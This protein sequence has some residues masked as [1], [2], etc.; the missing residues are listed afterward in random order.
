MVTWLFLGALVFAFGTIGCS[1][2]VKHPPNGGP[3]SAE[4]CGNRPAEENNCMA[5][6]SRPGCGY[7][8]QPLNGKPHCQPAVG[9]ARPGSCFSEWSQSSAE[10]A[11]PPQ[12][13]PV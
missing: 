8:G 3:A 13:P 5:C 6:S 9:V 1:G 4:E 12:P 10:C 2:E 11:E 7:C